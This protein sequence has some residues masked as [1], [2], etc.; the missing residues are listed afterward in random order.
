L[1]NGVQK[2]SIENVLDDVAITLGSCEGSAFGKVHEFPAEGSLEQG[3]G[4]STDQGWQP[5][6]DW[7]NLGNIKM[8]VADGS[9]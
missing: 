3:C 4:L 1:S 2:V 7:V 6:A 5:M 8:P 9:G